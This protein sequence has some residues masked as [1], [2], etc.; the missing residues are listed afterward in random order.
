M[1]MLTQEKPFIQTWQHFLI[2]LSKSAH[3]LYES[4]EKYCMHYLHLNSNLLCYQRVG[5]FFAAKFLS[6]ASSC[7]LVYI[8]SVF[9]CL[10]FGVFAIVGLVSLSSFVH[11]SRCFFFLVFYVQM[12]QLNH[13]ERMLLMSHSQCSKDSIACK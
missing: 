8:K 2:I 6:L 12:E 7:S 4:K 5:F 9:N 11:I 3:L 13:Q 1:M 10:E